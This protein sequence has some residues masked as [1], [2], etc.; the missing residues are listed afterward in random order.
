MV[1]FMVIVEVL[2]FLQAEFD[3]QFGDCE[4]LLIIVDVVVFFG[5]EL[6]FFY[7]W[8]NGESGLMVQF[9]IVGIY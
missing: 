7:N 8:S 3:I 2:L 1:M 5:I 6:E 4:I 9:D